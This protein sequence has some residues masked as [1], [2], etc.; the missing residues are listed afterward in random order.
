MQPLDLS[1]R[2]LLDYVGSL[3]F[4]S[5]AAGDWVNY[6][7]RSPGLGT[8]QVA[9]WSQNCSWKDSFVK[10]KALVLKWKC[11][12]T[13][14]VTTRDYPKLFCSCLFVFVLNLKTG[15]SLP[16]G[17]LLGE[18]LAIWETFV[19]WEPLTGS[20]SDMVVCSTT[21][22]VGNLHWPKGMSQNHRWKM[23]KASTRSSP[24]PLP[25]TLRASGE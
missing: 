22:G 5:L 20:N 4:L 23:L 11:K 13:G 3:S 24:D 2:V 6:L 25:I 8:N 21:S 16:L 7:A 9:S 18:P 19:H 12:G 1:G 14:L 17:N 10:T 15:S